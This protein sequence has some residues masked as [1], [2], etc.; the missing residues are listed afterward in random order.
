LSLYSFVQYSDYSKV[1]RR[2][3]LQ[4]PS[5][6]LSKNF[7]KLIQCD[8]RLYQLSQQPEITLDSALFEPR[9]S[10]FED[11]VESKCAGFTNL[12]D[13]H[14]ALP[15]YSGPVSP[16]AGSSISAKNENNDSIGMTAEYLSQT[17]GTGNLNP[18]MASSSFLS[19]LA[20]RC[21]LRC[22]T[23][24]L[25][26]TLKYKCPLSVCEAT[27]YMICFSSFVR[28]I[29]KIEYMADVLACTFS[30]PL[31]SSNQNFKVFH[32]ITRYICK[33]FNYSF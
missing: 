18:V 11:P 6:L 7:E 10:I 5:T 17:V 13:E 15:G 24:L 26:S 23:A 16:C 1:C 29:S 27:M 19:A 30:N 2:H 20:A 32:M 14:E 9:S 28:C 8:Q 22:L 31:L 12:K 25:I 3:F 4:C 21:E 33:Y